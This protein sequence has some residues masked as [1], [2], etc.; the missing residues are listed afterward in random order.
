MSDETTG[1]KAQAAQVT[2]AGTATPTAGETAGDRAGETASETASETGDETPAPMAPSSLGHTPIPDKSNV[3]TATGGMS[4]TRIVFSMRRW[5]RE[6]VVGT[7]D[8]AEVIER[9]REDCLM[10]ERY[11]FLTAMSA[12]IAVANAICSSPR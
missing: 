10:S 4:M 5:W 1:A 12:G 6:D 3:A 7:V 2:G 8:Q 11:L 9:R